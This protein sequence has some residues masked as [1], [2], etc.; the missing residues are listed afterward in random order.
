TNERAS[1]EEQRL[2]E[3]AKSKH[4]LPNGSPPHEI[5]ADT[6]LVPTI[7][8]QHR[9]RG[10]VLALLVEPEFSSNPTAREKVYHSS[11]ASLNGLEAHLRNTSPGT[12]GPQGPYAFAHYDCIQNT[13]TILYSTFVCWLFRV[14]NLFYGSGSVFSPSVITCEK[15]WKS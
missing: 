13:L 3:N 11:V 9:V 1:S 5:L 4:D 14:W 7:L 12:P 10:L 2:K 6:S 8:Y 15:L